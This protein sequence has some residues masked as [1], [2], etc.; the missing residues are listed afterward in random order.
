MPGDDDES[1]IVNQAVQASEASPVGQDRELACAVCGHTFKPTGDAVT[2]SCPQCRTEI[3]CSDGRIV[4]QAD[5]T[6]DAAEPSIST[7]SDGDLSESRLPIV[8]PELAEPEQPDEPA[9]PAALPVPGARDH[10]P[11]SPA[12][13]VVEQMAFDIRVPKRTF[14]TYAEP[15]VPAAE[16]VSM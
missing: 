15:Q 14:H 2:V 8:E 11:A 7:G 5:Q 16:P 12:G 13:P 9:I 1:P 3:H 10:S 4:E 6:A